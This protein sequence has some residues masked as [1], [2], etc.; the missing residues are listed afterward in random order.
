MLPNLYFLFPHGS[1]GHRQP[2]LRHLASLWRCC[3][4]PTAQIYIHSPDL[5]PGRHCRGRL[6]PFI[7]TDQKASEEEKHSSCP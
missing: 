5:H 7:W 2:G 1:E 4:P 3:L 6:S